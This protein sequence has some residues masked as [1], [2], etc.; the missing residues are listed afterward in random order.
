MHTDAQN[1]ETTHV[2]ACARERYLVA[3]ERKAD[4]LR[5][6]AGRLAV[7]RV[8]RVERAARRAVKD[9]QRALSVLVELVAHWETGTE[10][11]ERAVS[12]CV[13]IV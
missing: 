2:C 13:C 5:A 7:P 8:E 11:G 6:K 9:E 10:M 12:V 3:A 4:V 1:P